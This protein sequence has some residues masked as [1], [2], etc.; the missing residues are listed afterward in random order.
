MW[1]MRSRTA[2]KSSTGANAAAARQTLRAPALRPQARFRPMDAGKA[3]RS[4]MATFLPGRT[5]ARQRLLTGGLGEH[6]FN[7]AGWLL[8]L[9]H[10][11]APGIKARRNHAAVVE[12]QQIA[13]LEE[14][15][16]TRKSAHPASAPVARSITSMRL[17]P[18]SAGGCCAINSSGK[19]K[20]KSATRKAC[21]RCYAASS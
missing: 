1:P 18:R 21:R 10:Q 15:E 14:Q 17:W 12:H 4:P 3:S 2:K 6:H 16:E 11:R 8:A 20:S 7:A 13:R 5:S 19:S 9:A